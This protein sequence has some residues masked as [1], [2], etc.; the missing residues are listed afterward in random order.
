MIYRAQGLNK[1]GGPDSHLYQGPFVP[2]LSH[3]EDLNVIYTYFKTT[4]HHS[5]Y[6]VRR[7]RP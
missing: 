6:V 3:K 1:Y 5:Y 7:I 4:F 2:L